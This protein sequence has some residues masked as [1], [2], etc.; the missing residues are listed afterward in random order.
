MDVVSDLQTR[1][2]E[3][4]KSRIMWR[5]RA[6]ESEKRKAYWIERM[7]KAER[8]SLEARKE[9]RKYLPVDPNEVMLG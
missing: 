7:Y 1:L 2:C 9:L 8:E 5:R 6:I 4:T 3:Q